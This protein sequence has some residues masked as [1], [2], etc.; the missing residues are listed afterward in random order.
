MMLIAREKGTPCSITTSCASNPPAEFRSATRVEMIW[1]RSTTLNPIHVIS[2]TILYSGPGWN[3]SNKLWSA[4]AKGDPW[5][6]Q[7]TPGCIWRI[8]RKSMYI[9]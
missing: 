5:A 8:P 7:S 4:N 9:V 6:V 3:M 1:S 2:F